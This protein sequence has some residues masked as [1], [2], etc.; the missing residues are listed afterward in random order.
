MMLNHELN[1]RAGSTTCICGGVSVENITYPHHH[2]ILDG[3]F[4]LMFEEGY[5]SVELEAVVGCVS[6]YFFSLIYIVIK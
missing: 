4:T 3:A 1:G 2:P 5:L 6:C